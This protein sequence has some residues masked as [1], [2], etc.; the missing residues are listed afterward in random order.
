MGPNRAYALNWNG[1]K[2]FL[3]GLLVFSSVLHVWDTYHPSL[4]ELF[5]RGLQQHCHWDMQ[6]DCPLH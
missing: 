3:L 6:Q 4:T 2:L 1:L 5:E